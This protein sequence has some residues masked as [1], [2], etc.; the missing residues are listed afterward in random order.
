[1]YDYFEDINMSS[2]KW[3]IL[4][5]TR[6]M[7]EEL[8]DTLREKGFYYENRFTKSYEKDIQEAAVDWE[9]LKKET[10]YPIKNNKHF[11]IHGS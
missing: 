3:L 6:H 11:S 2:E 7:L 9:K 8:E 4:T 10:S 1:M 5:R